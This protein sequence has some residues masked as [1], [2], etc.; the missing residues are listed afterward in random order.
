MNINDLALTEQQRLALRETKA[1][2]CALFPVEDVLLFGSYARGEAEEESDLDLFV[3]TSRPM[4]YRERGE[5]SDVVYE[6]NLKYDVLIH[7]LIA[8]REEWQSPVWS[9]LPVFADIRREGTAI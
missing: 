4:S 5:M 8:C 7:L 9:L 2:L 6:I 1:E 3:L